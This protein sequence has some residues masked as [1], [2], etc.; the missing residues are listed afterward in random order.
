MQRAAGAATVGLVAAAGGATRLARLEQAG[1]ARAFLP[2]VD[3]PVPEVVMLNTAGGLT[4]GDRL[5]YA[6]DLGA[7]AR[8]TA[9][10]QTAERIYAC[11]GGRA[12]MDVRL[13]LG[14][15]AAL[16]WLPQETILFQDGALTRRTTADLAGEAR[17][18]AV[19]TLVLGRAAMGERLTQVAL[20]DRREVWRAGRPV[21]V[22]AVRLPGAA[23]GTGAAG[24]AGAR[25]VATVALVAPGAED[26]LGPVRAALAGAEGVAAAASAWDG[27]CLVRAMAPDAWPLRR[28]LARVL[29]VLRGRGLPRVWQI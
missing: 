10:T 7:G 5:A 20:D 11:G 3:G 9:T 28:V 13:T 27:R 22:E 16:D 23:L 24:L 2:R 6:V 15:G 19:E 8:A 17:L 12:R 1:A 14:P 26:A 25:A 18:L 4:G 29:A 21:L